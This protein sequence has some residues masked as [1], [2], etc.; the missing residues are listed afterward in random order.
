MSETANVLL[1][2]RAIITDKDRV[3]LLQRSRQDTH[4]PGLWEFPGGKVDAGEEMTQGLVREVLE[5]T[6]LTIRLTSPIAHTETQVIEGGKYEGRLYVALF[7]VA[8]RL[9]GELLLSNEHDAAVWEEPDL[10]IQH[11][12]TP[13]SRR[14]IVSLHNLGVI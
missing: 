8:Q 14:A 4:N 3:L 5:E 12:L 2:N 9:S 11:D 1:V 6:G 10:A 7:Y 13:E